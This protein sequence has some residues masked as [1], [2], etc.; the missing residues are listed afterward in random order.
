MTFKVL[1]DLAPAYF[2]SFLHLSL[3]APL[4]MAFTL[5][6]Q[7][8][9]HIKVIPNPGGL[10][11]PSLAG[12]FLLKVG[13]SSHLPPTSYLLEY[14]LCILCEPNPQTHTH[15]HPPQRA[16]CLCLSFTGMHTLKGQRSLPEYTPLYLQKSRTTSGTK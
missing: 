13:P 3:L 2:F 11:Y 6:F 10:R 7:S 9:G 12:S 15:T 1:Y 4:L 16:V 5:A 8:L 14:L